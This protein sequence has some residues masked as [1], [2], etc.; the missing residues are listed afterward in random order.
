MKPPQAIDFF[1]RILRFKFNQGEK[2]I[3]KKSIQSLTIAATLAMTGMTSAGSWQP[4][5]FQK[6]LV[7]KKLPMV[8]A[9]YSGA[10]NTDPQFIA[11]RLAIL[12]HVAAYS[13]LIDEGRWD[14]WFA[15]FSDDVVFETTT[16]CFGTIVAKGKEA[17]KGIVDLRYR[18][19][20]SEK[21]TTMRRHTQGNFH[22]AKQTKDTAE[23]RTYMLISSAPLEGGFKVLTSG[24][25]NATLKKRDGKWTIT[26]W[27]IEVDAPLKASAIPEGAASK[28]IKFIPDARP[29]CKKS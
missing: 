26:R 9:D 16:P 28:N 6:R 19:P 22:V 1:T 15:L 3:M 10:V 20:G 12:N 21:N 17:F 25:Y 7:P 5:D 8:E 13:Y 27:Y 11:D 24:T 14:E 29:E 2:N 4:T 18:A 23:V